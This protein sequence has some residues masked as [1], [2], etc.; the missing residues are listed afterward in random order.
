MCG[1]AAILSSD[2]VDP[3]PEAIARMTAA[4]THRGP[5]AQECVRLSGCHLGHTRLSIIDLAGGA[6]P[7]T[8]PSGR[9][10][11]VFNGEIYNYRELKK[12]LEG[13]GERFAT[14]S[15]TEALLLGFA[16]FGPAILSRLNGQFA[17][18]VWDAYQKTL[19]AARDRFGEKPLYWA[20]APGGHIVLASEIKSILA[21]GLI[22]P[23]IDPLSVDAYLGLF[24]VPPDRTIYENIQVVPPA[25][26]ATFDR[27]ARMTLSRYWSPRFSGNDVP[28]TEAVD[29]VRSLL[30]QAV[31]RQMVADVPVG[32]FLSGGLD[33]STIVGLMSLVNCGAPRLSSPKSGFP[34]CS[35]SLNAGWKACTT[36]STFSV[37]FGDLIDELPFARDVAGM[38]GTDH[39]ELQMQIDVAAMLERMNSVYDEPFGDSSNI[40]TYLVAE[41]ASHGV[42]AVLCGDGGDEIFGGYAWYQPLLDSLNSPDTPGNA[43]EAHVG[44][45][46][47]A[48]ADRSALWG[49]GRQPP[50]AQVIRETYGARSDVQGM[51]AATHFDVSCYLAGDILTKVDRAAMAHGLETRCPFLDVDLAEYVLGLSWHSRFAGPALKT[52]LRRACEPLWPVSVRGR[53]KQG[54][55][56]PVRN[57][58]QQPAV[59]QMWE[60]VIAPG[61]PLVGLLPGLP[62]AAP[63]FRPQR[64]WTLLCLGLWLEGRS[65]CLARLS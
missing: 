5:D 11:I 60:R 21:S 16:R 49:T 7:M 18:A 62:A 13:D 38:Y 14:Q 28:P 19:F 27:S 33:S 26:S 9:F 56:A 24:Y 31:R 23:R 4:L 63:D 1:I 51:D 29:Q 10:T 65:E 46:T 2:A 41:H 48:L 57:W 55:G 53:G 30:E 45:A 20:K 6:Q 40:P 35:S 32:A 34:A 12:S 39:H 47:A 61:A 52:L 54:F 3:E 42:K 17:F 22:A 59:H 64:R 25:H 58:L 15:D 44:G 37:G 43:W 50:T 8:D 36:I